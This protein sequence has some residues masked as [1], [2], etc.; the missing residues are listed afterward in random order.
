MGEHARIK[1]AAI[2]GRYNGVAATF[3][4]L[5]ALTQGWLSHIHR[6]STSYIGF[7]ILA[8]LGII[9]GQLAN[10]LDLPVTSAKSD[11]YLG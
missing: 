3:G 1:F 9:S 8:P 5:G 11:S 6:F 7:Y 4:S 10:S 2:F